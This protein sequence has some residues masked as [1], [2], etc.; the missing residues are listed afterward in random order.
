M[1]KKWKVPKT[2]EVKIKEDSTAV[3][4]QGKA[5]GCYAGSSCGSMKKIKSSKK[6]NTN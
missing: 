6:N 1:S 2:K 3:N 5:I 4:C